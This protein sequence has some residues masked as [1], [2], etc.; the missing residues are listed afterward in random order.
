[1]PRTFDKESQANN[2]QYVETAVEYYKQFL[3]TDC[4]SAF[5]YSRYAAMKEMHY[6]YVKANKILKPY[7]NQ[8][9]RLRLVIRIIR[10]HI[11]SYETESTLIPLFKQIW[12]D[13]HNENS[14]LNPR[15]N[16]DG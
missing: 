8:D 2:I 6:K 13:K 16:T 4:S 7:Y 12:D 3:L 14:T 9:S 11:H 1:M 15:H 10:S 5:D